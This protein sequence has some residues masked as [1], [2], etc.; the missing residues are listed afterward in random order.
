M[1]GDARYEQSDILKHIDGILCT[2]PNTLLSYWLEDGEL[3]KTG[4]PFTRDT[5]FSERIPN[6]FIK[7]RSIVLGGLMDGLSLRGIENASRNLQGGSELSNI[8]QTVPLDAISK[9]LF[10]RPNLSFEDVQEALSPGETEN[11]VLSLIRVSTSTC[12]TLS[13]Q[14][15]SVQRWR[16]RGVR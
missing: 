15:F 16:R 8:L 12:L 13:Y 10:A 4:Q 1:P 14:L 9:I 5:I 2:Q 3:D 7:T 6:E 11:E